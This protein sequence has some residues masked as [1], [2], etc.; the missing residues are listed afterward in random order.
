MVYEELDFVSS[1]FFEL[2]TI[3]KRL[4]MK[5]RG[6]IPNHDISRAIV[7]VV[8]SNMLVNKYQPLPGTC[9]TPDEIC[10][11]GLIRFEVLWG[12]DQHA[13]DYDERGSGYLRIPYVWILVLCME[14]PR[15]RFFQELQLFDYDAHYAR[16][17][18]TEPGEFSWEDFEKLM[19]QIRKIKSHVFQDNEV[20]TVGDLHAGAFMDEATTGIS[21]LNHKLSDVASA[22]QIKTHTASWNMKSWKLETTDGLDDIDLN[23]RD[24]DWN[25]PLALACHHRY[26]SIHQSIPIV[27]SLLSRGNTDPNILNRNGNSILAEYRHKKADNLYVDEIESLLRKAGAI[28]HWLQHQAI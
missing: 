11:N 18:P 26:L 27:R 20:T 9:A 3:A 25:T 23:P 4:M 22:V 12:D 2:L 24:L 17:N 10:R 16:H 8:M 14:H 15:D 6:V 19:L 7:R 21:F 1:N 5:Y 13:D 28:G